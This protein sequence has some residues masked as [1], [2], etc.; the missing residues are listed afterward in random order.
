M[1]A[2]VGADGGA[3]AGREGALVVSRFRRQYAFSSP[4]GE[5]D[6]YG[7]ELSGRLSSRDSK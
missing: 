7:A 3:R 4:L 1:A 6:F 2:V 5:S